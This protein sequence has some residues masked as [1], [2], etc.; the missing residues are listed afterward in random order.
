MP[1]PSIFAQEPRKG[2]QKVAPTAEQIAKVVTAKAQSPVGQ[3]D[4]SELALRVV[5]PRAV[6]ITGRKKPGPLICAKCGKVI[7]VGE[8]H[9]RAPDLKA[10]HVDCYDGRDSRAR[11][12]PRR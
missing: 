12:R 10:Y 1:K 6:L 7:P 4:K 11:C 9:M 2:P 3:P 8:G 5:L